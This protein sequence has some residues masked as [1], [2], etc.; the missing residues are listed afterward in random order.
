MTGRTGPRQRY[1]SGEASILSGASYRQIDYWERQGM[2][3]PRQGKPTGLSGSG[4]K[5]GFSFPELVLA[6]AYVLA[7]DIAQVRWSEKNCA[8]TIWKPLLEAYDLDEEL[9]NIRLIVEPEGVACIARTTNAPA[10]LI[11]NLTVCARQVRK[12]E[13]ELRWQTSARRAEIVEDDE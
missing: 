6:R 10:A 9:D 4:W 7:A 5:R 13:I 12:R 3:G 1:S 2:L 8:E 11:V